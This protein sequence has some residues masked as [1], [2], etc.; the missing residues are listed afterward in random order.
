MS[1]NPRVQ[2]G[3]SIIQN[4]NGLSSDI[5]RQQVILDTL[6]HALNA[7]LQQPASLQANPDPKHR[8]VARAHGLQERCATA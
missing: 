7:G 5:R 2:K 8:R 1:L 3:V 4:K 6:F